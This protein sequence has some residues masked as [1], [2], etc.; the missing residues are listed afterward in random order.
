MCERCFSPREKVLW[1]ISKF[2]YK[3]LGNL[4]LN[5]QL[6]QIWKITPLLGC[7]E[8][9][10][11]LLMTSRTLNYLVQRG[12]YS[13]NTSGGGYSENTSRRTWST[14]SMCL[15]RGVPQSS[16]C[17][18]LVWHLSWQLGGVPQSWSNVQLVQSLSW[19]PSRWC[20]SVVGRCATR[21]R[22][23][24]VAVCGGVQKWSDDTIVIH[25]NV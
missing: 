17:I 16:D 19:L 25:A 18:Q 10:N 5:C 2:Q 9:T 21:T 22:I 7:E 8:C 1:S 4:S 23:L 13:V 6:W 3:N 11:E 15:S 14:M 20:A 12:G 24:G